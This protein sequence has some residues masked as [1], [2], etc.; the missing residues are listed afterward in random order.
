MMAKDSVGLFNTTVTSH[1]SVTKEPNSVQF[2]K[3]SV[4]L[5]FIWQ[6]FLWHM[7]VFQELP[8]PFRGSSSIVL[9]LPLHHSH[10]LRI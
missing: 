5:T 2:P 4:H 7:G 1:F 6:F 3:L 10:P 9:L 8:V